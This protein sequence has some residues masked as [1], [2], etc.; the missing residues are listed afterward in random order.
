[1]ALHLAGLAA[2]PVAGNRADAARTLPRGPPGPDRQQPHVHDRDFTGAAVHRA[3]GGVL[4]VSCVQQAAGRAAAM[5]VRQPVSRR[6]RAPGDGLPEPVFG[7]SQPG[8]HRGFRLSAG[9]GLVGDPHD[10]PHAQR[11]LA[12][13][14]C[15]SARAAG[16]DVLGRAVARS[17]GAGCPAG[18][19]L[20]CGLGVAWACEC[21]ADGS[22]VCARRDAVCPC[23]GRNGRAVPLR[24][25]HLGALGACGGRWRVRGDGAGTGQEGAG[26]VPLV[27]AGHVGD[28]RRV[29]GGADP[30]AVGV[31]RLAGGA[32]RRGDRGLPASP[33]GGGGAPGRHAGLALPARGGGGSGAR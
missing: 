17:A 10:R 21:P 23:G 19:R 7:Q 28:L 32:A 13:A 15:P 14:P 24:A 29:R 3:A 2:F 22:G 33:A 26:A 25:Q 16:A 11:D 6:D 4:G 31:H 27:A 9:D 20:V 5:A 1:M 12:C 18:H 30:A 8:R